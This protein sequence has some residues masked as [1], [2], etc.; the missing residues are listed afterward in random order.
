MDRT[1]QGNLT[2][3]ENQM[4]LLVPEFLEDQAILEC[5]KIPLVPSTLAGRKLLAPRQSPVFLVF[6]QPPAGQFVRVN[7]SV[8]RVLDYQ[9]FQRILESLASQTALLVQLALSDQLA[10]EFQEIQM[11]QHFQTLQ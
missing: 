9:E 7:H 3:P 2:V 8:Q 5:Q 4:V 1:D 10:L 6:R 11:V